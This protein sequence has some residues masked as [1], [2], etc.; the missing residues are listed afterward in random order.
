MSDVKPKDEVKPEVKA[1][2][3]VS[4]DPRKAEAKLEKNEKLLVGYQAELDALGENP[5]RKDQLENKIA[6]L[7]KQIKG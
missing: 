5:V 1:A 6:D 3:A 2:P 4:I 7:K